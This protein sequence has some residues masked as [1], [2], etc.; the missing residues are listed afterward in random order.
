M[1]GGSA[2]ESPGAS[3]HPLASLAPRVAS[4]GPITREMPPAGVL[5]FGRLSQ[6]ELDHKCFQLPVPVGLH[7]DSTLILRDLRRDMPQFCDLNHQGVDLAHQLQLFPRW[8]MA[9]SPERGDFRA[10]RFVLVRQ[11]L[12][13]LALLGLAQLV[14]CRG[15]VRLRLAAAEQASVICVDLPGEQIAVLR[16][17]R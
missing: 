4:P 7:G 6:P 17:V 13:L 9:E 2:P 14:E 8:G 5:C 3:K 10:E 15:V 11:R 1:G 16:A 12:E